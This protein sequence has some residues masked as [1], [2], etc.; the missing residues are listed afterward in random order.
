MLDTLEKFYI[1]NET[2]INNQINDIYSVK[3]NVISKTL[4][5]EDSDRAHITL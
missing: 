5:L 4:I 1:Y 3:P 2:R